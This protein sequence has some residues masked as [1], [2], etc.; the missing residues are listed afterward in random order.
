M[1]MKRWIGILIVAIG[2]ELLVN[3]WWGIE[4]DIIGTMVKT[5]PY[6][7]IVAGLTM[8]FDKKEMAVMVGVGLVVAAGVMVILGIDLGK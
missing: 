2:A 6:L 5:W 3:V 4:I 8:I 1:R 7:L